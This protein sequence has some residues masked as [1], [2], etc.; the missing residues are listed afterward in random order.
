MRSTLLAQRLALRTGAGFVCASERQRDLWLGVLA[1]LGRIDIESYRRDPTLRQL[2]DVV[3]FGLPPAPPQSGPSV[4]KGVIPGIGPED[5]LLV[6]GGGVW[7]W[8][9]PLTPIRAVAS[10]ARRRGD[11]RLLFLG[12]RHPDPVF[13]ETRMTRRAIELSQQLGVRDR[14]VFFNEGWVRYDERA[15]FLLEADAGVSA[16]LDILETRYA[17][18]TRILDYFLGITP[19]DHYRRRRPRGACRGA[20]S[21]DKS[22]RSGTSTHGRPRWSACLTIGRLRRRLRAFIASFRGVACQSRSSALWELHRRHR[23][24]P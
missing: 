1:T 10:L 20:R 24:P 11:V 16:H 9:D 23:R 2:I 13:P 15:Q 21:T 17:F 19:D 7:N 14:H 4:A 18:R 12:V 8:L 22:F 5:R 6:W 3:P